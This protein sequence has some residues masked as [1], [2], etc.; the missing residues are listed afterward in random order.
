MLE[1]GKIVE[2][3]NHDELISKNGA[4]ASMYRKQL[5]EQELEAL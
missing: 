4:Y 5:I 2:S 1:H 3:G